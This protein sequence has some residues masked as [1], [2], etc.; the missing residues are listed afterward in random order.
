MDKYIVIVGVLDTI[1]SSNV[2]LA[3]S[4]KRNNIKVIPINYRDIV[5]TKGNEFLS[6]LLVYTLK[7]YKPMLTIFCKCNGIDPK[8]ILNCNNYSK[9][10]LWYMDSHHILE[11]NKEIIEIA[12]NCNFTSCTSPT[13]VTYLKDKGVK[14]CIHIFEGSDPDVHYPVE[15]NDKYK[16]YISFIGSQTQE[17]N[18]IYKQLINYNF[19]TKYYGNGYSGRISI[20]AWRIICSSSKIM[21]SLNTFNDI[22][23]Y[24]SGR[25]FEYMACGACVAHYDK[26]NTMKAYFNDME[27][28][29]LFKTVDEL[30]NKLKDLSDEDL[31]KIALR[32][33]D[34]V[35]NNFTFDHATA[36]ILNSLGVTK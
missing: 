29:I 31:G 25:V 15:K 7:K 22:P 9:T 26:T 23:H 30:Y 36:Y 8:I 11:S 16:S 10:F 21:L 1:S 28:I 27:E 33:R 2:W 13:T 17:R 24:F 6:S 19:T 34:T 14:N 12:K 18:D 20:D 3:N 35:L 4:F 32:G 5:K